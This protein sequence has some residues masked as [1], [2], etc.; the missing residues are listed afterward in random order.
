MLA[1]MVGSP[2]LA[3][4]PA[5]I[6]LAAYFEQREPNAGA[7]SPPDELLGEFVATG[8]TAS[9]AAT[10]DRLIASG[11]DRVVLVPNPAGYRSTASMLEQMRRASALTG[12]GSGR[13]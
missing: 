5:G 4:S 3:A 6:E 9:C 13:R 2:Q 1:G 10:I 7:E 11:A 8:N 12:G